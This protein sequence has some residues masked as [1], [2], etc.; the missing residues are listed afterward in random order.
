MQRKRRYFLSPLEVLS[1][2][3]WIYVSYCV[4]YRT[5]ILWSISMFYYMIVY[6]FCMNRTYVFDLMTYISFYTSF[7][8]LF[9]Y[10]ITSTWILTHAAFLLPCVLTTFVI[11]KKH[12]NPPYL[13]Y[14]M[15]HLNVWIGY[16]LIID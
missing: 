1:A 14:S 12:L 7:Y 8:R 6:Y 15:R 9:Y 10:R 11:I 5:S 16:S 4:F 3:A 2:A 13:L